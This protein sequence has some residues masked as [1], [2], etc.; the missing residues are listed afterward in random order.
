MKINERS[1]V[2]R[3]N[4]RDL[5]KKKKT[6]QKIKLYKRTNTRINNSKIANFWKEIIVFHIEKILNIVHFRIWTI[7]KIF[8][9][10]NSEYLEIGKIP[11]VSDLENKKIGN[12]EKSKNLQF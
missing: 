9:L 2:E 4:L 6:I 1:N 12:L 3:P 10:E 11:S 8:D 7:P 5:K